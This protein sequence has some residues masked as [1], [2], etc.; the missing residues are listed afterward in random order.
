MRDQCSVLGWGRYSGGGHGNP[1]QHSCLENLMD[2][3]A[4]WATV[5]GSQRAGHNRA[6]K[7]TQPLLHQYL[8]L[9]IL[10]FFYYCIPF[11]YLNTFKNFPNFLGVLFWFS[12]HFFSL[13]ISEVSINLCLS[14]LIHILAVC[15]LLSNPSKAFFISFTGK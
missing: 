8:F 3:G 15:N 14:S 7:N 1:L 2:R 10:S 9:S 13:F 6:T 12:L 4:W 5:L 11:T